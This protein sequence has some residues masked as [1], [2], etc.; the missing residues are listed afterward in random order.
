[1]SLL[2]EKYWKGLEELREDPKCLEERSREFADEIPLFAHM[3]TSR[4]DF[5]KLLGFSFA[6]AALASC[7]RMPVEKAIPYLIQPEDV[8]PGVPNWYASTCGG[9]PSACGLLVKTRDGRPI[10]IEGNAESPLNAGGVCA[11]GQATVLSLYDDARLKGPLL[12]GRPASWSE[13]DALVGRELAD[14]AASGG[15]I[16]LLSGT[17]PSPSLRS[18]ADEW[19]R[20]YPNAELVVYD[21]VSS[22]AL[23]E[24]QELAFGERALPRHVFDKAKVIVGLNCDFLGTWISPVEFTRAYA[25]RRKPDGE[26]VSRHIQFESRMSLTGANADLRIPVNPS[27]ELGVAAALFNELS[28]MAGTGTQINAPLRGVDAERVAETA[29][30]LWSARGESLVVSGTN[31]LSVQIAVAAINSLLGNIGKTVDLDNPS[32]QRQGD[33]RAFQRLADEL[34]QGKIAALIFAGVNPVYDAPDGAAFGQAL[35]KVRLTVSLSDRLDETSSLAKIV[36]PE[37][38]ALETWSDAQ[39]NAFTYHVQQPVIRPLHD[40]RP[41]SESL[42]RWMGRT[43]TAYEFVKNYWAANLADSP[44]DDCVRNGLIALPPRDGGSRGLRS[45]ALS[46]IAQKPAAELELALFEPIALRDGRH[47]N[48]P[49]LQ[50]LPDPVTK[51]TW[52]NYVSVAPATAREIGLQDGDVV[53]VKTGRG[54]L[55]IPV[56]IQPGQAA[57]TLAIALGYGRTRCGKAGENVG[58]NAYPLVGAGAATLEKTGRRVELAATQTHHSMEGRPIVLET[59]LAEY[60][61]NPAAGNEHREELKTLWAEHDYSGALWGMTI[62]LSACTG[63]SACVI[64]CQS[65]N[66]VPVVGRDEVRR[67]REMHWIRIDRYYSGTE[68]NPETVHQPMMCQHC[69]NAPCET[70]CPVLATVHSSDGLNQQVYNRCVGTRYCANNCPYKVRRFNWFEYA[71]NDKFDFNMNS[72]LGAM[73]LNPD[74]VVRSRGVMEKCS[75]CIQRIQEKKLS[76]KKEG[77][78]LKDGEIQPA[79]AQSC[80]AQ[81]IVFGNLNDPA[82]RTAKLNKDG[83]F[84]H[85]LEELNVRPNVGYLTKVRNKTNL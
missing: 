73:V 79:C 29:K 53:T 36:A 42:L 66:N 17:L 5:L 30:E 54:S 44:W 69:Q 37:S 18:L 63:C 74:I 23:L 38:H 75:L 40:T 13:I 31:D 68:E 3:E 85:V 49:W 59:T 27:E 56:Q 11:T 20:K 81:A 10:K 71:R 83:R 32:F 70:V 12:D 47:A 64:G 48:N 51:I 82:S 62:D 45:E 21:A 60:K 28:R 57:R 65:E 39:P 80:P 61:K 76:A 25:S 19:V 9:C 4:R 46:R 34:T 77:R 72:E 58:V 41:A 52:D 50:E 22:S 24:A 16:V 2:D 43:E 35:K 78:P 8:V 33:D 67:R 84:Y 15:K 1:M 6:G 55:E 7:T 26:W 14:I